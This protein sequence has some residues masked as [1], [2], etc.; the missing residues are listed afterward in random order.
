M[1]LVFWLPFVTRHATVDQVNGTWA[2]VELWDGEFIDLQTNCLGPDIREGMPLYL[3]A[4]Q[5][6]ACAPDS[7]VAQSMVPSS[8]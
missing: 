2:M 3:E 4:E 6:S 1:W 5:R 8:Q 7:A